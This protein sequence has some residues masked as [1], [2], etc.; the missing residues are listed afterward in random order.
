MLKKKKKEKHKQFQKTT[1]QP[2]SQLSE[3]IPQPQVTCPPLILYEILR[4]NTLRDNKQKIIP[5]LCEQP[6]MV[7]TASV[8]K[9]LVQLSVEEVNYYQR[10]C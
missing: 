7:E 8:P 10:M 3:Q 2:A 1:Q 5:I 9:Q 4:L 6:I